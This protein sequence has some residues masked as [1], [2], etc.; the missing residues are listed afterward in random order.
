MGNRNIVENCLDI[1][2]E[3]IRGLQ[4]EI[5]DLRKTRDVLVRRIEKPTNVKYEKYE[6]FKV[7]LA[8]L[9]DW[10][11]SRPSR[12]AYNGFRDNVQLLLEEPKEVSKLIREIEAREI[13]SDEEYFRAQRCR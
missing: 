9:L 7:G 5:K 10:H 13:K 12:K 11:D 3:Y 6:E 2:A 4:E 1:C 8:D